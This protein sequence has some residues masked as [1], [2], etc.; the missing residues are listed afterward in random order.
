[1]VASSSQRQQSWTVDDIFEHRYTVIGLL[2]VLIICAIVILWLLFSMSRYEKEGDEL[3]GK[4]KYKEA[5]DKYYRALQ[6]N[7]FSGKDRLMFKLG[8]VHAAMD[9]EPR[10][11]DFLVQ[12]MK[13]YPKDN[14]YHIKGQALAADLMSRLETSD[15]GTLPVDTTLGTAR[16]T[17]RN[18]YRKLLRVLVKGM[19]KEGNRKLAEKLYRQYKTAH[20]RYQKMLSTEYREAV[21]RRAEERQKRLEEKQDEMGG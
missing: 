17:F 11:I 9:D 14:Y 15:P 18:S 10:A 6:R 20:E 19:H 21:K 5:S 4:L 16:T 13:D 2:G 1:M 7:T 3:F 8:Q 12:L